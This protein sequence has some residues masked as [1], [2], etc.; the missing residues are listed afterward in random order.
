MNTSK[1]KLRES[2]P[3]YEHLQTKIGEKVVQNM[4]ICGK[5]WRKGGPDTV[6]WKNLV[7]KKSL[8]IKITIEAAAIIEFGAGL[9]RVVVPAYSGKSSSNCR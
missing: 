5:N 2:G 8:D 4:K 6:S 1:N 7:L 9:L 3:E